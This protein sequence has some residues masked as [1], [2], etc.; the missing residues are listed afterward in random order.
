[1]L[2]YRQSLTV[3]HGTVMLFALSGLFGKWLSISPLLIVFGRSFFATLTLAIILFYYKS[4]IQLSRKNTIS[5]AITG[6]LLAL[7]WVTFF[8]AIQISSVA[9][10]LI[11]F[12]TFPIFV[13]LIEPIF[14]Q[15]PF[16]WPVLCQ[17]M[18]SLV[19][20]I[21]VLSSHNMEVSSL[22]G[23]LFGLASALSFAFLTILNRQYVQE[24]S[25]K[26]VALYQNFFASLVLL[27]ALLFIDIS[28]SITQLSLLILLGVVFTALAHSLF[29]YVLKHLTAS[30][31]SIS[32]SLEPV[33]GIFAA[34]LLLNEAL[35]VM[36][37][38]GAIIVILANIWATKTELSR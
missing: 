10:G 22:S 34:Y 16:Y 27:P 17:A 15:K 4:N 9:I 33:Y 2:S 6:I 30:V 18:L 11:T 28:L 38:L 26:Q 14:F 31:V 7:H 37:V 24:I 1:M 19:G 32:V 21:L 5:L 36:M 13:S 12:A 29:N 35:S 8:Q 25:A 23:V 20:V 3:L